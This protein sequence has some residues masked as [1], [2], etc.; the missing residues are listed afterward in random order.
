MKGLMHWPHRREEKEIFQQLRIT[1]EDI[2]LNKWNGHPM[3]VVAPHHSGGCVQRQAN[4]LQSK[5]KETDM[6]QESTPPIILWKEVEYFQFP[7]GRAHWK[8]LKKLP[9]AADVNVDN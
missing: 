4:V 6:Q 5:K 1:I 9:S 2:D 7:D 3:G 8:S